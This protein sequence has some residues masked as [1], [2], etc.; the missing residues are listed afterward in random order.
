MWTSD[1]STT[2][3]NRKGWQQIEFPLREKKGKIRRKQ[4]KKEEVEAT[5]K[6]IFI[7]LVCEQT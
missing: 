2:R 7:T 4:R 3:A 1:L 6:S 5:E